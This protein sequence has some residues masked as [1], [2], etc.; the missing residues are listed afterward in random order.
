MGKFANDLIESLTDA[1]AFSKGKK[2]AATTHVIELPDK[3]RKKREIT[4]V[5]W[6]SACATHHSNKRNNQNDH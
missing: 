1:V 4:T 6:V 2:P 3:K 5:G